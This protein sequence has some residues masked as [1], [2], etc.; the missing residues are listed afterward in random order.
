MLKARLAKA[1]MAKN[2]SVQFDTAIETR[3]KDLLA[4]IEYKAMEYYKRLTDQ[5]VYDAFI[6]DPEDYE[7]Y[8]HPIGLTERIPATRVGGGHQTLIALSIRLALMDITQCK[9]LLL[10]DEPTDGV[11]SENMPQ[12]AG[13][14]GEL[15]KFI[16]QIIMVTHHNICEE[17][18]ASVIQVYADKDGSHIKVS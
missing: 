10:L 11:D 16:D 15:P 6:V 3:R 9:R 14:L 18:S 17:S 5:Q 12:L 13:Y 1:S 4:S 2:F 7:V 8:V